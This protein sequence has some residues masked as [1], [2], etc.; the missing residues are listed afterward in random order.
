MIWHIQNFRKNLQIKV[1]NEIRLFEL[2]GIIHFLRQVE[3]ISME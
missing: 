3:E 2:N 1:L